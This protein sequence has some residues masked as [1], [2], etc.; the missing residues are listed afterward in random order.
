M[1]CSTFGRDWFVRLAITGVLFLPL[2]STAQVGFVADLMLSNLCLA[3][4][5]DTPNMQRWLKQMPKRERMQMFGNMKFSSKD[6]RCLMKR[7]PVAVAVCDNVIAS[8]VEFRRDV[9]V[10]GSA[11]FQELSQDEESAAWTEF[12]ESGCMTDD[13]DDQSDTWMPDDLRPDAAT[14]KLLDRAADGDVQAQMAAHDLYLKGEELPLNPTQAQF[15]AVQAA[16][17]G[18]VGA[19]FLVGVRFAGGEMGTEPDFA[20]AIHFLTKAVSQ[21]HREAMYTLATIYHP[22]GEEE[23]TQV[24]QVYWDME[25]SVALF[26]RAANLGER[27]AALA[28][29]K[30]FESGR[31]PVARDMAKARF[32]YEQGAKFHHPEAMVRLSELYQEGKGGARDVKRAQ[33]WRRKADAHGMDGNT[34]LLMKYFPWGREPRQED[35]VAKVQLSYARKGDIDAQLA[36]A[37]RYL[38]GQGVKRSESLAITWW[39]RAARENDPI[40]QRMLG[41]TLP[42]DSAS[43]LDGSSSSTNQWLERA[44]AQGDMDAKVTSA[45]WSA[46]G[47]TPKDDHGLPREHFVEVVR[48]LEQAAEQGYRPIETWQRAERIREVL[49][50]EPLSPF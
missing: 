32:W 1:C 2:G 35:A 5:W 43:Q 28:L 17:K 12:A 11:P 30:L 40:A 8:Y 25:K 33:Y 36:I 27:N 20:Q 23:Q 24:P 39:Q 31:E 9:P 45:Y 18:H 29:A 10:G 13:A 22:P 38:H 46:I 14:L 6:K 50:D 37:A 19:Q 47:K 41:K 26:T 48:I 16:Q 44:A 34:R 49:A 4:N 15:W 42:P 3:Q 7:K 21:G